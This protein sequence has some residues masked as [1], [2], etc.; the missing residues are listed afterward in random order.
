[1]IDQ[2]DFEKKQIL[3][4]F[5]ANG[6][7][8]SFR[9]DNMLIT[10]GDGKVK[11]QSTCYR[12]FLV[13][14][15][16]DTVITTGLLQR[17]NKF[18]FSICL[19]NR[20][21]KVYRFIPARMEGNTVLRK[22]QYQY[23]EYHLARVIVAN[24]ILNQRTALN[25]IRG[26]TPEMKEAISKLDEHILKLKDDR[27]SLNEIMGIEGSAAR[28]Y[29]PQIFS[30]VMWSGRKP[31]VKSDY[32]NACLDIGYTLLFNIIDGL[33]NVYGFDEYYGVLH[34]CFYMRKSLVCD[35]MEPFRAIVDCIVRK[36]INLEQFRKEDFQVYNGKYQL[37]WKKSGKYTQVFL[38]G[39]L[40]YKV[41]IFIYIQGYYRAFMKHKPAE[42][43]PV[44]QM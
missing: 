20:N 23:I 30:N 21:L 4:Y 10:D 31:R 44:F 15:A 41:D 42:E 35:L 36:A 38:E 43:F 27:L 7:K 24:K 39:I 5:P 13:F 29:F 9:N 18:G 16:G 22:N 8:M 3:F 32:V 40:Q 17:A 19:M 12:I 37:D 14:V 34:R 25:K 6:D 28:C 33:V 26:K 1:M 11:Y 2:G